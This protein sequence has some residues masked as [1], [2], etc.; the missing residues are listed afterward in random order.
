[1]MHEEVV[2]CLASIPSRI[3]NAFYANDMDINLLIDRVMYEYLLPLNYP[4][5]KKTE[6]ASSTSSLTD[7]SRARTERMLLLVRHLD[8]QASKAFFILVMRQPKFA[9][10]AERFLQA[11][12]AY[13]SG[14]SSKAS[15]EQAH[16]MLL[17]VVAW[18][19]KM[20]PDEARAKSDLLKFAKFNDR[21]CYQLI[22][23]SISMDSDY[24]TVSRSF[25][26][27]VKRIGANT[28]AAPALDT[29]VPLFYRFS[30]LVL[31]KSHISVLIECANSDRGWVS[32]VARR[33]L[34]EVSQGEPTLMD[35]YSDQLQ[36]SI[37]DNAPS[38]S[39]P[40]EPGVA[41]TLKSFSLFARSRPEGVATQTGF[42][43]KLM[44]YALFGQPIATAKHAV[45]I[46]M[47]LSDEHK[48]VHAVTLMNKV[49]ED[50]GTDAPHFLN[51]L[52]TVCQLELL[53]PTVTLEHAEQIREITVQKLIL[54]TRKRAADDDPD[55]VSDAEM[56]DELMAKRLALR[57]AVNGLRAAAT[58]EGAN[59]ISIRPR[60]QATLKMLR[61]LIAQRGEVA[62]AKNTPKHYRS[63]LVLEA[64]LL[65]LK[66]CTI[67][68]V[69]EMYS[70]A[71]FNRLAL[72]AQDSVPQVRHLFVKK[73]QKYLGQRRLRARFNTI[74]FL[75]AF[76]P[77]SEFRG[78]I[79]TWLRSMARGSDND[80]RQ[81]MTSVIARL[82]SLLAH[83]PD[84]S[85]QPENLLDFGRYL[86]YFV[87]LV[88]TEANL[89]RIVAYTEKVK[90]TNDGIDAEKTPR[91]RLLCDMAQCVLTRWQDKKGWSFQVCSDKVGLPIG[92][93][94]PLSS[95]EEAQE[96]AKTIY[97][98]SAVEE[99]LDAY[100]RNLDRK[101]R[102]L[103]GLCR[104]WS[105][106]EA[107]K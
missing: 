13:G 18:F 54:Q 72:V 57:V 69:D 15:R 59:N 51:R 49:M 26:E 68:L 50:F 7:A 17:K 102:D 44:A 14:N 79:E 31:N 65:S 104:V 87:N 33:F 99:K 27:M 46:I 43:K 53:A 71:D 16:Q 107:W 91:I 8:S 93:Y 82:V 94:A 103:V 62:T 45:T 39:R 106:V 12:E 74:V 28:A 55:W 22:R 95:H 76:E 34:Q 98:P 11:C 2:S 67:Q 25:K 35:N 78:R 52:A 64:A 73:L 4:I 105:C 29:L 75:T 100:I 23:F 24:V 40:N 9:K 19:A 88:A 90:Q 36:R 77:D 1:M 32:D 84:Y 86:V 58:S 97:L 92:L 5:Q 37:S 42:A 66:L 3:I 81:P 38:S 10:A 41:A 30:Y 47:S 6:R 48:I 21:R 85:S 80:S 101:A 63:R 61:A 83:H 89:G 56:D 60:G 96:V 20:L 70:A